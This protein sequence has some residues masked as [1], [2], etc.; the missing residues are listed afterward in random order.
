MGRISQQDIAG[1]ESRIALAKT[2]AA[3]VFLMCRLIEQVKADVR[4]ENADKC[5][6][7]GGNHGQGVS[8]L[9]QI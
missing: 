1:L 3:D 6:R 7:K 9:S 4:L 5:S 2:T 8:D